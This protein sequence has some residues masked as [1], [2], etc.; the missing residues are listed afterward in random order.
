MRKVALVTGA[1]RR[2][3]AD[4]ARRLAREN[5]ELA[6]FANASLD[7]AA[8]L[9]AEIE[10]EGGA[11]HAFAVDLLDPEA[12]ARALRDAA[13]A[14]GPIELLVNNA[15]LFEDD[16]IDRLDL[17]LWRRQ[18]AVD[19]ESPVFLIGAFAAQ[20]PEGREG[21]VVNVIDQRVLKLTPEYLSYTLAKSAL[22]TA[23]RTFAQ[24]LAPRIRVNAVGPGPTYASVREGDA[25][26]AHEAAGT[27]FGRPIAGEEIAEAVL[28]LAGARNVTGQILCVDAA[29]TSAGGRL[30]SSIDVQFPSGRRPFPRLRTGAAEPGSELLL[31]RV[32]HAFAGGRQMIAGAVDVERQHRHRRLEGRRLAARAAFRRALQRLRY[33]VRLPLGEY[34]TLQIERSE[35]SVTFCDHFFCG[36]AGHD[37][38]LR[39]ELRMQ[40]SSRLRVPDRPCAFYL[41]SHPS[42][43]LGFTSES[44]D[45][46]S[47]HDR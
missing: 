21:A 44:I 28:Y 10:R 8:Q 24:A 22:W 43:C 40:R 35:R 27:L 36:R 47:C 32:E 11:A 38:I 42:A 14:M 9:A 19:L 16:A 29:S 18:F 5:Y 6:L 2:I 4:I 37:V 23:T 30:I 26:L 15:A 46:I 25:G 3:G 34:A 31:G 17:G 1:G 7:G 39:G 13:A 41:R 20:L 45:E 12:A 33:V